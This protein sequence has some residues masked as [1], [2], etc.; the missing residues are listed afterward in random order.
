MAVM[1]PTVRVLV[2]E[3]VQA[4]AELEIRELKRAGA[5]V[6]HRTVDSEEAFTRALREFVPDVILSD[7]TMP[8]FDGMAALSIAREI[9]P[10]TP[11]IFVSGSI[12]EEYAIRALKNGATDY[13][14]KTNL[15]RLP[16][17]V[18]RALTEAA[19]RR[20]R[21]RTEVELE[22]ARERMASIVTSIPDMLW[23]VD[24]SQERLIYVSPAAMGIF[25]RSAEEFLLNRHLWLEVI[26]P[27]DRK[28][29]AA[30]WKRLRAGEPFEIDCRAVHADGSV[31]WINNRGKLVRADD[32]TPQRS[33]G[34]VRDITEQVDHRQ[35]IARLSRIREFSRQINSAL[36][37]LRGRDE[38]FAEISRI[39]VE[40]GGLRGARIGSPGP[41]TEVAAWTTQY[42]TW[43]EPGALR[44]AESRT[45]DFPLCI[46]GSVSAVLSLQ[47]ADA[48]FFEQ[49][50]E[51]NL[52]KELAANVSFALEL[53]EQ[54]DRVAYLALYD[55][56]T[57]LANRTLFHERLAEHTRT[58][59]RHRD[60][61]AVCIFDIE[62]FKTVND[63]LGAP[64]G[65]SL[66]RQVAA[67]VVETTADPGRFGRVSADG[68]ALVI[69]D[70][71]TEDDA[72]RRVEQ[73]LSACFGA[74]FRLE[75]RELRI[76]AKAGIAIFP[77]DG[78]EGETL[79]ANAE[80]ACKKAKTTHD[81]YLFYTNRMNAAVAENLNLENKL[82]VALERDEFV[83]HYQPKVEVAS[84]RI[85]GVEALIRWQSPELGLVPPM[86][87]I[88]L[89]E[90]TGL[91]LEVGR[92]A[93][94]RAALDYGEWTALASPRRASRSMFPPS[95]FASAT[96]PPW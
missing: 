7:F 60:R 78:T 14:L 9:C 88:P 90:E 67:R 62:R 64:A 59:D 3:D 11:F 68:F 80:A 8:G 89:M 15:V 41:A 53:I 23:S 45:A 29:M 4:D 1:A 61:F 84:R 13:V 70:V 28:L 65:D 25:G 16:V 86:R 43:E 72:A 91:I 79:F 2:S 71:Q 37:R 49:E 94:R 44:A 27:D 38:L 39:A 21:R 22:L 17:T 12:G 6:V 87:F 69:P 82:R 52:L 55:P 42:G 92:W 10:H 36:V 50:E 81:R 93:L 47:A 56:L 5:R 20:E 83:L 30:A 77:N 46:D 54:R 24:L 34:V 18:E 63:S 76:S 32:G 48:G 85:T 31:R 57:G 35:R 58:A 75:E 19:E 33:E 66:L 74:P 96:L 73:E 40:V 51:V 26:H 95:S